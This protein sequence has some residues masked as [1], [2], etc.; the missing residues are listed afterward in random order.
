MHKKI[1]SDLILNRTNSLTSVTISTTIVIFLILISIVI[2]ITS[3]NIDRLWKKMTKDLIEI[4][5]KQQSDEKEES[6]KS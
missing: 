5:K 6:D 1:S 4:E 2:I 3:I